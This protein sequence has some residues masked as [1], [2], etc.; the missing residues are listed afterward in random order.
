[1]Y[2]PEYERQVAEIRKAGGSAFFLALYVNRTIGVQ[3]DGSLDGLGRA[4]DKV[5]H[6]G[7]QEALMIGAFVSSP[8]RG[9]PSAGAR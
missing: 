6:H 4:L 3:L 8:S 2:G 5:L 7:G 1:M 9:L